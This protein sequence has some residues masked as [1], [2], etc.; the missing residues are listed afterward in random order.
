METAIL[1]ILITLSFHAS[2]L[3]AGRNVLERAMPSGKITAITTNHLSRD[4]DFDQLRNLIQAF[5]KDE[6]GPYQAIRWF[7]P[8]GTVL[9]AQQRCPQ[10]GGI[11]HALQKEVVQRL[12]TQNGLHLG[13]ILTG[14]PLTDFLDGPHRNSRLKQYQMEKYL[15]AVDDGWI[16]RRARYYR[17]AIQSE[18]EEAWGVR[19]LN[20]ALARNELI[21]S[22]FFMLRQ[23]CKDIPH[24]AGQDRWTSIR[25]Q[26][27]NIADAF[28]AFMSLRVKLHGQPDA[29][30]VERLKAFYIGHRQAMNADLEKMIKELIEDLSSVYGGSSLKSLG[31]YLAGIPE[32]CPVHNQLKQTIQVHGHADIPSTDNAGLLGERLEAV[33]NLLWSI[34][35]NLIDTR[36]PGARLVMMDLSNELEEILFLD[37]ASWHP[38]TVQELLEKNFTLAKAAA[39][40]GFLEMWEWAR[41]QP[42]LT[43]PLHRETLDLQGFLTHADYSRRVAEW[44]T[45][46]VRAVYEPVARLFGGF[47]PLAGG[48]I[49]DRIRSS[50]LLPLGQVGGKLSNLAARVTGS[51]NSV[52]GI[53]N[54][55]QIRGL[56][57]G[58][59]VGE[60]AVMNNHEESVSFKPDRIY[61]MARA[62]ADLKPVAGIATVSEGNLVSHV[63]LL[64]RN[65]GIPNAVLSPQNLADLIPFAGEEVFYAVS[66]RGTVVMKPKAEMRAEEKALVEVRRRREVKIAVPVQKIDLKQAGLIPLRD[67]R[68]SDSGRICGP[69]AANLGQLKSLFPSRVVQGIV[70]PFGVFRRHLVLQ[71][72][73]GDSTFWEFLQETFLMAARDRKRGLGESDIEKNL[74]ERLSLLRDAIKTMPLSPELRQNLRHAFEVELGEEIGKLPVFIRSDTNM[75][76]LKDFTGAGLNLTVFNV[77]EEEKILQAIR[78]VWASPFT[79]RSYRWRQKYLLNPENVYPSILILPTVNV[80]RSGVMIT[81][82]VATRNPDDITLAF[83][84]GAGGAVEGQVSESYLLRPGGNHLLLSPSRE[85][86]CTVLPRTGGTA[87][88]DTHLDSPILSGEDLG[89]LWELGQEI[90]R[91]LPGTPG[92][93]TKGPFDV[94]LGF[95]DGFI[96]LFQVRP[97]VENKRATASSYLHTLDPKLP[98]SLHISLNT[99]IDSLR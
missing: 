94:E 47:E 91:K 68:A 70:I 39:G 29:G 75:E 60:L 67:L 34:R 13:Q 14:T 50:P 9:P 89:R 33:A 66:P 48:F 27:R 52:M 45:G 87:T 64:A 26:A 44:G 86:T 35:K 19:F 1:M 28:P 6:R 56:N 83:S 88:G 71:M 5:K 49:D 99:R 77:L 82:G 24:K 20:W 23:T 41:I 4:P 73:G 79:E 25:A 95:K 58:F 32:S 92:I 57:A 2:A 37:A 36:A 62:P 10:P 80:D 8:D 42:H 7:C 61:I 21:T 81:A 12:A 78:D 97:F 54:Q 30:D 84:R 59:A 40:C 63:Q 16:L 85:T 53:E 76:D 43:P 22:Q 15:R 96:W 98:K 65:L 51:S 17:G 46:M 74:L 90:K 31:V 72:P 55:N 38:N 69:K 11:Q 18:D 93:E 3:N